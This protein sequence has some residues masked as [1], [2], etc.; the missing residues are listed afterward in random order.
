MF[1]TMTT[2]RKVQVVRDWRRCV[3]HGE[4]LAILNRDYGFE[5][6]GAVKSHHT[7]FGWVDSDK[8][9][10]MR[11]CPEVAMLSDNYPYLIQDEPPRLD[12]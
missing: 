11:G 4:F 7:S 3:H 6:T 12:A 5:E 8:M 2:R 10:A 9:E 1:A